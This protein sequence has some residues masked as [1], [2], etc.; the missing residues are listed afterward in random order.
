[1]KVQLNFPPL[2]WLVAS[3]VIACY[4][5]GLLVCGLAVAVFDAAAS[6]AFILSPVL[7]PWIL[8]KLLS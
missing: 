5:V 2:F 8:W 7:V 4:A 3:P 6:L 1:M